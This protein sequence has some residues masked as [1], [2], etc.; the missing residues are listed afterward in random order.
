MYQDTDF[1]HEIRDAVKD[2]AAALKLELAAEASYGPT[3]T[4]FVAPVSK[5]KSAGC[6]LVVMGSIIRDS[7]QAVGTAK[8]LGWGD[9]TLV[10]QAASYDPIV[11]A[12]PGG[13]MEGFY[14]G[15]G[16]PFAYTDTSSDAIKAWAG[17]YKAKTG[18][19]P[20]SA[21]QYGYVGADIIVKALEAAGKDLTRATF[22]AALES[23]KDY[24]P[25][26]PGPTLSYG[27]DRHQG[28]TATF[29]AKVEGGRWKVVAENLLY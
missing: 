14:S 20:N 16:M 29:L 2:E 8:K 27:A 19:D 18:Q 26:F 13:I 25:F 11:A 22:L 21:A 28:S 15:T 10:G 4:D 1:G 12:A 6:E 7:I 17:R 24:K 3:D 9:V 23:I 5:L